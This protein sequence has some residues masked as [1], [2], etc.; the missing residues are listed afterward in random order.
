MVARCR[1]RDKAHKDGAGAELRQR[2][3]EGCGLVG[4]ALVDIR[5]PE[6][7]GENCQLVVEPAESQAEAGDGERRM[8]GGATASIA[9]I[10]GREVEP[11]K[12]KR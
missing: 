6:L 7:E 9:A 1:E 3:D 12:P 10:R 8:N 11:V 2:G 4:G 5:R